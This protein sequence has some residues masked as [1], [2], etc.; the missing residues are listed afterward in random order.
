MG[1]ISSGLRAALR[2]GLSRPGCSRV[3]ARFR[4]GASS[5][6][7][8][9]PR[10]GLTLRSTP[11]TASSRVAVLGDGR[12]GRC[13]GAGTT[14]HLS[15][16]AGGAAVAPRGKA[17]RRAHGASPG[18][19]PPSKWAS[20]L[21]W[22]WCKRVRSGLWQSS[23]SASSK[24]RGAHTADATTSSSSRSH[25]PET[26]TEISSSNPTSSRRAIGG[27][28]VVLVTSTSSGRERRP[29]ESQV[30][31]HRRDRPLLRGTSAPSSTAH[32]PLS[33]STTSGASPTSSGALVRSPRR[34]L[35]RRERRAAGVR[36]DRA[37]PRA[38]RERV[39]RAHRPP[40]LAW[41][42]V[43]HPARVGQRDNPPFPAG[44]SVGAPRFELGTSSP[45]DWRANQA[46]P[47]PAMNYTLSSGFRPRPPPPGHPWQR[48]ILPVFATFCQSRQRGLF[49]SSDGAGAFRL[50]VNPYAGTAWYV[51]VD[52]F[53]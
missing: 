49:E 27:T 29:L 23:T 53:Q 25:H 13:G 5:S 36:L 52:A 51:E 26:T 12:R 16:V 17:P 2:S 21:R 28:K 34:G 20:S 48:S 47:R 24:L 22:I 31:I 30:Q 50:T 37:N 3:A 42:I 46:A 33:L 10:H 6:T 11:I 19:S 41:T 8:V 38:V 35:G 40:T 15:S 45:P 14:S 9:P 44:L 43:E 1:R 7:R 32:E 39:R 18:V 4:T